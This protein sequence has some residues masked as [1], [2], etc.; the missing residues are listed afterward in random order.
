MDFSYLSWYEKKPDA[1][2][3]FTNFIDKTI[4]CKPLKGDYHE[5]DRHTV[6]HALVS[7]KTGHPSEDWI[8]ANLR[9]MYG[10]IFMK[11]LRN[12]FSGEG[13]ATRNISK[14]ERLQ[15]SLHYNN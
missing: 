14:A 1:N 9:Y 13:N 4:E 3:A 7:F 6:H 15:D 12:H 11:A 8:K 10:R 5:A 2:G